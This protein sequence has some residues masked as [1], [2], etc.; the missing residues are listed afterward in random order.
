VRLANLGDRRYREFG[1][2][3]DAPGFDC[4]VTVELAF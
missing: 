2:G 1:S 4:L 3:L